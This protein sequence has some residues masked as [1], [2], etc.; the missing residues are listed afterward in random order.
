MTSYIDK[1][2][3]GRVSSLKRRGRAGPAIRY[4]AIPRIH[5]NVFVDTFFRS[6]AIQQIAV[7]K[8]HLSRRILRKLISPSRLYSVLQRFNFIS[9][10]LEEKDNVGE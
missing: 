6:N 10:D 5:R 4:Y 2:R 1:D 3:R 9:N 7:Q 8:L